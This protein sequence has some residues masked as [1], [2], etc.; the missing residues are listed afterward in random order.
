M[1]MQ[2]CIMVLCCALAG[3]ATVQG[4]AVPLPITDAEIAKAKKNVVDNLKDPDSARFP[5]TFKKI[6][7]G[8]D[9]VVCGRVNARNS[10]GGYTGGKTF[11]YVVATDEVIFEGDDSVNA[12]GKVFAALI[13]CRHSGL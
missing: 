1:K 5:G 7:S 6:R 10:F 8:D 13:S 2:I 4:P 9:E 11:A 12:F 3:C